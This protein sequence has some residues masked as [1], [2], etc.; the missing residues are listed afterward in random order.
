MSTI[1]VVR[2]NATACIAADTLISFDGRRLEARYSRSSEKIIRFG[3]C[4]IGAAGS[5][6]HYP[7]LASVAAKT[8]SAP[9]LNTT[10]E[11][12]EWARS[13][14]ATLK[15]TY[16]LNPRDEIADPYE[17]S[18]MDMLIA[19]PGGIFGVLTLREV[20]EYD[21]YWAI[22]SGALIAM[23]AMYEAYDRHPTAEDIARAGMAAAAEFDEGT[24]LPMSI[25][26]ITSARTDG[27]QVP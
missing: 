15:E 8:H 14:H 5:A 10:A 12:F 13:L 22:G 24:G 6:A 2:K 18:Q 9:P 27:P 25:Y 21:R 4:Y 26:S 17:S 11:I 19:S 7:V 23:G 16:Y 3:D 20:Y 1:L